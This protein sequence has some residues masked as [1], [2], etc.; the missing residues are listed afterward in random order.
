MIVVIDANVFLSAVINLSGV[1]AAIMNAWRSRR[2]SVVTSAALRAELGEILSRPETARYVRATPDAVTTMLRD[3]D[4]AAK[5]VEPD[6]VSAVQAD[7]D[8]DPV[9]GTATAGQADYV[10][11]GDRHLLAIGTFRGIPIV[12]PAQ[13]LALLDAAP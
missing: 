6:P 1:P 8:D 2:F 4:Q 5:L 13:F 9:L 12:T 3:L 7:P 11:T 10:V